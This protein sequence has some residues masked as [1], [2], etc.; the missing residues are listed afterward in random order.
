LAS[1]TTGKA[2]KGRG[3]ALDDD[4]SGP[5]PL[6]EPTLVRGTPRSVPA[7]DRAQVAHRGRREDKHL[8]IATRATDRFV[9][10]ERQTPELT[11]SFGGLKLAHSPLNLSFSPFQAFRS[12]L[13][14]R[15]CGGHALK[16]APLPA[17]V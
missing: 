2:C 12:I 3:V 13:E 16:M 5:Q 1:S 17:S 6:E 14:P 4:E 7:R 8:R 15:R 9:N 10:R 11:S